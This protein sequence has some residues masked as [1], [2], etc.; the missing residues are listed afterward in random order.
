MGSS[1]MQWQHWA[2]QLWAKEVVMNFK[3]SAIAAFLFVSA[4]P[5]KAYQIVYAGNREDGWAK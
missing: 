3:L 5:A 1:G 2:T 4:V